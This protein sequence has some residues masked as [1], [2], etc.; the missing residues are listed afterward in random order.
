[1]S[2]LVFVRDA[3]GR[4]LMPMSAAYA[5]TLIQQGKAQV[6][7]HPAFSVIQLTRVVDAPTLRPVLVG[8]ALSTRLADL[9]FIIDQQRGAPSTIHIVV[10]LRFLPSL[11]GSPQRRWERRRRRSP[12]TQSRSLPRP[13]D[14]VRIL[15][16][17]LR[18]CYDVIPISH[19]ILLPSARRTALTP[20]HAWWIE[21]RL[22]AR[23]RRLTSTIAVV[24]QHTHLS[25]EVPW[26]LTG[27]LIERMMWAARE[28]PQ[29]VACVP[30][31][32]WN[33][34][35]QTDH[36]HRREQ[37]SRSVLGTFLEPYV[38][39]L[40]HL[41]T[42]QQQ[43][44]TMTGVL[45]A[46]E[47][48]DQLVLLIPAQVDDYQGVQ[49]QSIRIRITPSLYIWPATPIWLLPLARAYDGGPHQRWT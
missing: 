45:R 28:S 40:G 4:P 47:P 22:E 7:R 20:P 44:R 29:L 21:H 33:P 11:N 43:R 10:D 26:E 38:R 9:V 17:V 16:A 49:W 2:S 36:D 18:T 48:P 30:A 8:V 25:G 19:L 37:Q 27:P 32:H 3:Q 14:R 5:R 24:H 34:R 15:M 35:G 12:F 23:V 31:H 13:G 42:V 39:W 1:M 46:L 41:C 6:W